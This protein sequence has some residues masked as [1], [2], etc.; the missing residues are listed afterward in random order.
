VDQTPAPTLVST[1]RAAAKLGVTGERVRQLIAAGQLAGAKL[2]DAW[3]LD[4]ADVDR[5]AAERAAAR[6]ARAGRGWAPGRAPNA[7]GEAA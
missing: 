7:P 2:G 3:L 1:R 5:L 6:A 4:E